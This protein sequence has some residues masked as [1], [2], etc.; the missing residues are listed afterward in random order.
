MHKSSTFQKIPTKK[1]P[2]IK[3]VR[4]SWK[5]ARKLQRKAKLI[6]QEKGMVA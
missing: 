1:K 2:Q 6:M 4:Q 3:Y 5:V